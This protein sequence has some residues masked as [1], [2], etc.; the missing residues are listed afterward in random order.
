MSKVPSLTFGALL[1]RYRLAAGLTQEELAG[2]AAASHRAAGD[3][4]A[5]RPISAGIAPVHT[6]RGASQ[7]HC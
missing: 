1:K 6:R 5:L 7:D 4:E 3:Q 2:R